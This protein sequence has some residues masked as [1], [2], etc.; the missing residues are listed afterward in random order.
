MK[1]AA[2]FFVLLLCPSLISAAE[3]VR[4][5]Y[6]AKSLNY[7][8]LFLGKDKGIYA[9]EGIDLELVL[10][11]SR[12]QVTALTTGD[13]EFSGAQ[14]QVSSAAALGFPVKVVGFIT[15]KPTFWLTARPEI[16]SISDL[17]GKVIGITAI[18]S[19][20]DTLARY[21]VRKYGLV[22]DKEVALFATGT[23]ANILAALNGGSVQAGMLSPPFHSMAK[24]MG[25]H[26]LAYL[27]DHVEQSLSG[28]ATSDKML[29][30]RPETVRRVLRATLKSLRFVRQN[31]EETVL[32][33]IR[34]WKVDRPLAE[35]LYASMLPA[36]SPDGSMNEKGIRDAL[37]REM[38]RVDKKDE[39][40]LSRVI[41]LRPLREAQKGL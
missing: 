41:D 39:I 27:G 26:I 29:R 30:E 28:V 15:I 23:T 17:K 38:G 3:K 10:V 18:G 37:E 19:S 20:T 13:L 16:R 32:Y 40:P 34:E 12:I 5:A 9:A 11:T 31:K 22:P 24:L 21:I 2:I 7:L 1:R 14:S 35:E 4:Y 36:F 8:P 6:P 25:F 33:I